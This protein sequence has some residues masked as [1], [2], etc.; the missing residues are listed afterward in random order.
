MVRIFLCFIVSL[1]FLR[2]DLNRDGRVD[3]ADLAI[4][5]SEWLMADYY[6]EFDGAGYVTVPNIAAVNIG[7]GDISYSLFV[8][9][10]GLPGLAGRLIDLNS[11]TAG[12]G[13]LINLETVSPIG[14]VIGSI[15]VLLFAPSGVKQL[16]GTI[17]VA[18]NLWHHI[19][20]V[21][22]R[23]G[24][25]SLYIDGSFNVSTDM[26]DLSAD[27]ITYV[28]P[29]QF[30]ASLDD[31]NL[32]Y[33]SFHVGGLDDIR[34]YK[35]VAL[36]P[37]QIGNI[38]NRTEGE[39]VDEAIFES[40]TSDGWYSN[41]NDGSGTTLTG[42]H[43]SSGSWSDVDGTISSL[44]NVSWE[45]ITVQDKK[46]LFQR[47][48]E[49]IMTKFN[50]AEFTFLNALYLEK[51]KQDAGLDYAVFHWIDSTTRHTFDSELEYITVQF[52]VYMIQVDDLGTSIQELTDT[53]D[54]TTLD[55]PGYDSIKMEREFTRNVG[56]IDDVWQV[57]VGYEI[58]VN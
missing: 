40:I 16:V 6:L 46:L 41:F 24:L 48:S 8:K 3:Y 7:T 52:N 31:S 12:S 30:A 5:S 2:S 39:F 11:E 13:I 1:G 9:K 14:P 10:D 49:A 29:W 27:S 42:R 17:N 26:S 25:M 33:S 21:L 50:D 47:V 15:K 4:F 43:L 19:A 57:A 22:D 18:D 38:N 32:L 35:G 36:T 45:L 20:I 51:A 44:H 53:F 34:V 58:L 56:L 55:I 37:T 23:D 54:W 28:E